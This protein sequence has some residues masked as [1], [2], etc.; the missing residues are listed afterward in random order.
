MVIRDRHL[1]LA[2]LALVAAAYAA[3][4]QAPAPNIGPD[5][6][7]VLS[8]CGGSMCSATQAVKIRAKG[9][10]VRGAL[11][12]YRIDDRSPVRPPL[13]ANGARCVRIVSSAGPLMY[14]SDTLLWARSSII[15]PD[16]ENWCV[17]ESVTVHTLTDSGT[18]NR[19]DQRRDGTAL[20]LRVVPPAP[21]DPR[22]KP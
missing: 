8:P 10:R 5:S 21:V 11:M 6:A 17:S 12:A 16:T 22:A 2:G 1:I 14:R 20:G 4:A 13:P 3:G 15:A 18:V 9:A 7:K 19:I